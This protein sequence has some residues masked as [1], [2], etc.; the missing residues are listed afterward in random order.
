MLEAACVSV[1]KSTCVCLLLCLK[2]YL[3]RKSWRVSIAFQCHV[4]A[5]VKSGFWFSLIHTA[6]GQNLCVCRHRDVCVCV[7]SRFTASLAG[8]FTAEK[9]SYSL[10]V[11]K[12]MVKA[13]S[14]TLTFAK[15]GGDI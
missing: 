1:I 11:N 10:Q 8:F 6:I 4:T 5:N 7:V 12:H 3:C 2:D 9:C 15:T 13:A 14:S